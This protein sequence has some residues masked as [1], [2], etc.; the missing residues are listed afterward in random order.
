ME[1]Y[2]PHRRCR[3]QI[4]LGSGNIL[5]AWCAFMFAYIQVVTHD[6]SI[7]SEPEPNHVFPYRIVLAENNTAKTCFSQCSAFGYPAAG[8]EYGQECC[9]CPIVPQQ[10]S[11]YGNSLFI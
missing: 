8:L 10:A 3:R 7:I 11:S 5:D 6:T 2:R 4:F 9:M 1:P